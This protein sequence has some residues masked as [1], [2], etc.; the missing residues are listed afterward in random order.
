LKAQVNLL[1][2]LIPEQYAHNWRA[3]P[4][5]TDLRAHWSYPSPW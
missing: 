2:I 3:L 4:V 1:V 5:D